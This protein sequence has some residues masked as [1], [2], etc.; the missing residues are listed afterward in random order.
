MMDASFEPELK[1]CMSFTDKGGAVDP[2]TVF[3]HT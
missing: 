2:S 3:T 1:T